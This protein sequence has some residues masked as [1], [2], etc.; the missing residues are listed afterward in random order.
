VA[1]IAQQISNGEQRITGVMIESNLGPA[2]RTR[3][4]A[5]LTYGQSITDGCIDWRRRC[6]R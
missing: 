3:C 5:K 6:P 4:R 1:D 2:A